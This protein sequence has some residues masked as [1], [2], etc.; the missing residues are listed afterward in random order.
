MI[1]IS[2]CMIVKNEEKVLARCLSSIKD[3]VDEIIIV[4]TGSKDKTITV[5][6]KFT[7]KVFAL[8]WE[9]NFSKA[10]N[11]SFSKATKP[12]IMWLDADDIL[13]QDMKLKFLSLKKNL[14]KDI[15]CVYMKYNIAF[16]E[17]GQTTFSY[18]R[19]RLFKK[20]SNPIWIDPIHE[21]V[22]CVGKTFVSDIEITHKRKETTQKNRNLKIYNNLKKNKIPFS[23]RMQ[24]YY[25]RELMYSGKIKSATINFEKFLKIENAWSQNK[26]EACSLLS[27]LYLTQNKQDKALD[28][29]LQSLKYETPNAEILC[30]IA[31]I[32][33]QKNQIQKAIYYYNL[34]LKNEKNNTLG[35][36]QNDYYDYIP[37]IS[38]CVLYW[39]LGNKKK[40]FYYNEL[41]GK[42]KPNDK[43]Y[44]FNKSLFENEKKL[45]E[46]K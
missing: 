29:L 16:D 22:S 24:Y 30:K 46:K 43:S 37:A 23:A 36:V 32:W 28:I 35:F 27:S 19:E 11:F 42:I 1:Q 38:L 20:E 17:N 12:Y 2:L 21:Y 45:G 26:V 7:N 34:A 31:E 3:C 5:A 25:S 14:K 44:L 18:L 13:K 39:K 15:S 9:N 40:S 8:K 33:T 41:A 10:R 6:K 4:D